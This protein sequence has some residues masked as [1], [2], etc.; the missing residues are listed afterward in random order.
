VPEG[1]KEKT[2][3]PSDKSAKDGPYHTFRLYS[4]EP[5][6]KAGILHYTKDGHAAQ[7]CEVMSFLL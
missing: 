1:V 6:S 4:S 5:Y 2:G 3:Y 7:L